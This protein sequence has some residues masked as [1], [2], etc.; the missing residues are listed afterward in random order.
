M[1]L[2]HYNLRLVKKFK[3]KSTVKRTFQLLKQCQKEM[4]GMCSKNGLPNTVK[5]KTRHFWFHLVISYHQISPTTNEFKPKF[6]SLIDRIK[7][8]ANKCKR[9]KKDDETLNGRHRY[10]AVVLAQIGYCQ[11]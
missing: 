8:A 6:I 7:V 4:F 1:C 5:S 2:A 9:E 10:L 11:I 3:R